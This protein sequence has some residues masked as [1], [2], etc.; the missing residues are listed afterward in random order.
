MNDQEYRRILAVDYGEKRVG[1]AITDPLRMFAYPLMTIENDANFW[2]KFDKIF[3]EYIVEL[4][5]LGYPLKEDGSKSSSTLLVE[6]FRE[7][8]FKRKPIEIVLVDERYS[9]SI[10]KERILQSVPSKKKRRNKSLVDMN[11]ASVILQDY[12]EMNV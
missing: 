10:A 6:K 4:I 11:A 2:K 8:L 9:S 1:I 3:T 7:E 5:V 12:L